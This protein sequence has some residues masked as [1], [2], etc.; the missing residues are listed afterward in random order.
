MQTSAVHSVNTSPDGSLVPS[1]SCPDFATSRVPCRHIAAVCLS[2]NIDPL[3]VTYLPPRWRLN[4]HPLFRIAQARL[5]PFYSPATDAP[6]L[7][8]SNQASSSTTVEEDA[9]AAI[10]VPADNRMYHHLMMTAK[11]VVQLGHSSRT[12]YQRTMATFNSLLSYGPGSGPAIPPPIGFAS[13]RAPTPKRIRKRGRLSNDELMNRSTMA[14]RANQKASQKKTTMP[15]LCSLC[16]EHGV[17]DS[18]HRRG[19][20]C[21]FFKHGTD[22]FN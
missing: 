8:A 4:R 14:M 2:K 1:C 9:Y 10:P 12:A 7:S 15:R 11:E 17:E 20:K 18:S 6:L 5:D 16:K 3:D 19:G 22:E 21:P 13:L